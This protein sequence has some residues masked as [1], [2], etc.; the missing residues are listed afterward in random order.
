[1][2]HGSRRRPRTLRRRGLLS[3]AAIAAA[4]VVFL[5]GVGLGRALEEGPVRP[6]TRT[7]FRTLHPATVLP[8][9]ETVT[10]TVTAP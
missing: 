10:V 7:S 2:T 3:L 6:D 9:R 1:M 5:L 4:G 8:A